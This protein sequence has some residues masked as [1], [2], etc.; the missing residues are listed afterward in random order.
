M[1]AVLPIFSR[2][3][4]WKTRTACSPETTGR[5]AIRRR[6]RPRGQRWLKAYCLPTAL[7]GTP[8]SL[9]GCCPALPR[10]IHP[11][12]GAK[13]RR[14]RS[15]PDVPASVPGLYRKLKPGVKPLDV[16]R[17]KN[18]DPR[19]TREIGDVECHDALNVA[20]SHDRHEPGVV[21]FTSHHGMIDDE[22]S[23]EVKR[24]D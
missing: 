11:R 4:L 24:R 10:G 19:K 23:P 13:I 8:R 12:A 14:Q 1:T 22:F 9:R 20:G 16:V 2:P 18:L 17:V 21:N 5:A 3:S 6:P 15:G 7:R